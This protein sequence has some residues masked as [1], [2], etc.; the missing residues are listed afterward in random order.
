MPFVPQLH[1]G[2]AHVVHDGRRVVIAVYQLLPDSH[3]S[4]DFSPECREESTARS[5]ENRGEMI[6][7]QKN[8][9]TAWGTITVHV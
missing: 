4:L 9:R 1:V 2:W 8:C 5:Q 7:T 6:S 3:P